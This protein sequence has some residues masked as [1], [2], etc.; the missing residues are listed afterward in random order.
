MLDAIKTR[1]KEIESE[2][3][4]SSELTIE[5]YRHICDVA[6]SIFSNF[7]SVAIPVINL[8][9]DGRLEF[10]FQSTVKLLLT[11][12]PAL[13]GECVCVNKSGKLTYSDI[14]VDIEDPDSQ[15][16]IKNTILKYGRITIKKEDFEVTLKEMRETYKKSRIS[17][18][19][20]FY[21]E[22]DEQNERIN[23]IDLTAFD[24]TANHIIELLTSL[25]KVPFP[26]RM[27][28]DREDIHLEW[29][30]K[31][32]VTIDIGLSMAAAN[33]IL[34]SGEALLCRSI[35]Y[36][37]DHSKDRFLKTILKEYAI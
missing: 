29:A 27:F 23:G 3:N 20:E 2:I 24:R 37:G 34:Y 5:E 18:I 30:K 36:I 4:S 22:V 31:I 6:I 32:I 10:E 14:W 8:H 9:S 21:E 11:I 7:Y 13:S 1:L 19:K 16:E 12:W 28:V 26:D 25:G 15:D 35:L 33:V 17:E